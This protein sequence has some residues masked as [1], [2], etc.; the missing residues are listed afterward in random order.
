MNAP[1]IPALQ[2]FDGRCDVCV[3]RRAQWMSATDGRAFVV[4]AE[5]RDCE[6][7]RTCGCEGGACVCPAGPV[8]TIWLPIP[9]TR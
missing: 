7:C 5:C 9:A 4:C 2:S 3:E 8:R 6:P 1:E